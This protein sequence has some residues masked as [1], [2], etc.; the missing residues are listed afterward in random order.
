M[1]MIKLGKH[2]KYEETPFDKVNLQYALK[3]YKIEPKYFYLKNSGIIQSILNSLPKRRI[4]YLGSG[5]FHYLSYFLIKILPVKPFL[6]LFDNHFDQNSSPRGYITCGSWLRQ[7]I[8]ENLITGVLVI[9][10]SK[11]YYSNELL[12]PF[13]YY[14]E[15]G[16]RF[17]DF[18]L[19]RKLKGKELYISID[20]DVLSEDVVKT[21]W[22]QGSMEL[23]SLLIWLK[24]IKKL[25]IVLGV[26]LCG[27]NCF[28]P[29]LDYINP[30]DSRAHEYVNKK[31]YEIFI[32]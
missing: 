30:K 25:G 22:D 28:D 8:E 21:N 7:C 24:F 3:K 27:E 32:N 15:D 13:L 17:M 9:G 29:I 1:S 26:D 16:N 18:Q 20:K 23:D 12:Y 11:K 31:I 5:D 19:M 2:R 14:I 4:A 10:A 6:I